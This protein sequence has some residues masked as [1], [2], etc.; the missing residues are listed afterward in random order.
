MRAKIN[1][2]YLCAHK[3]SIMK[4]LYIFLAALAVLG[5]APREQA[6]N[7]ADD[8]RYQ[9]ESIRHYLFEDPER[10]LAMVVDYSVML[11]TLG[12]FSYVFWATHPDIGAKVPYG[13][14]VYSPDGEMQFFYLFPTDDPQHYRMEVYGERMTWASTLAD[15]YEQL[16]FDQAV[17]WSRWLRLNRQ[18]PNLFCPKDLDFEL[19]IPQK[20]I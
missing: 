13:D 7:T 5:C 10:A 11:G 17:G 14:L 16:A 18:W 9:W 2:M 19:P 8:S 12:T 15:T 20:Q 6:G 4:H 1:F 3:R